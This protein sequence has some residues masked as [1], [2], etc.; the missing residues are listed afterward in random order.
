M[1]EKGG[2]SIHDANN[3]IY[4]HY[5]TTKITHI[6]TGITRDMATYRLTGGI[7]PNLWLN[8]VGGR[9]ALTADQLLDRADRAIRI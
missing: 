4:Q 5:N 3:Q 2:L 7:H 9:A 6:I 1:I 8:A